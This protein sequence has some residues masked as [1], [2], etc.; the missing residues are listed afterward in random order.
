[1]STSLRWMACSSASYEVTESTATG[2][3]IALLRSASSGS[4]SLR[5][6]KA[7]PSGRMPKRTGMPAVWAAA[8]SGRASTSTAS[9]Q[10]QSIGHRGSQRAAVGACRTTV[11]G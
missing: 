8:A 3:P 1:M 11:G 2:R 10:R 7:P 6:S 5:D 4:Q 9:A